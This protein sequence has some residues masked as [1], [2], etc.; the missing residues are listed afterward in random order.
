[1]GKEWG[2]EHVVC[3]LRD[4]TIDRQLSGPF[5]PLKFLLIKTVHQKNVL[6]GDHFD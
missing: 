5:D 2:L 6:E 3:A 4:N 1:M